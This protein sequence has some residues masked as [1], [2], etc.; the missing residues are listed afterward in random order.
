MNALQYTFNNI[1]RM[2]IPMEILELAFPQKRG[3]TPVSLEERM[4]IDCIRPIIMT[5]MNIL[6]GEMA[7]IN[8]GLCNTVAV[9]DFSLYE[10]LGSFIIEVPKTL[11]NNKSIVA[12]YSLLMGGYLN[13]HNNGLDSYGNCISP[14][15]TE[16]AKLM[17][18]VDRASVVQTARMELVGENK[19]LIEAYPPFVRYGILKV[20]LSNNANLENIQPSYY[21]HVAN[22]ITL[23]IKRYIYNKLRIQLDVGHIYAGHEIPGFKEIVDSYADAEEL[24]KEYLKVWGKIGVLNDSR[25]MTQFTSTMIG[26]L[27]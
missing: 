26:M 25:K 21:P 23:G 3:S 6:G 17:S 18:V 24:Y 27:G 22:L 5:D 16:G 10:Q 14:L 11:T 4:M 19:I 12:V 8:I 9:S 1:I 15:V 2:N 13:G 20:N 7:F